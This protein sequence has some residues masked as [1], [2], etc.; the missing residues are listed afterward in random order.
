M[1][2][3][4]FGMLQVVTGTARERKGHCVLASAAVWFRLSYR[5]A[6]RAALTLLLSSGAISSPQAYAEAARHRSSSGKRAKSEPTKPKNSPARRR[7]AQLGLGTRQVAGQLL[8]GR[9]DAAWIRAAGGAT[10]LPG[11]LKLPVA[12]GWFVRGFGSGQGG[13]HQAVDI[14]GEVG[15]NVR[16]AAD[17]IVGYAGSELSGYGNL[18]I[19][20]HP[21]GWITIYGHNAKNLA[22]AGQR[23]DRGTVI[24]ELG[25][26]GRSKGPHVH[27]ELLFGG[28]N[29]DPG[30]LFRPGIRRKNGKTV[31]FHREV[32]R[33]PNKRPRRLQ[34]NPRV[35]HPDYAHKAEP[36]AGDVEPEVLEEAPEGS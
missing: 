24:A 29:C 25:S 9:A 11:T 8:A 17:G 22:V 20:I 26:T 6:A 28:K 19:L 34:C 23:V 32:W 2:S 30:P 27:F 35:H 31:P 12:K 36:A 13:Y 3:A 5:F 4:I 1:L 21:G 15:W 33:V 10:R 14:G 7:A 18:M 16:A